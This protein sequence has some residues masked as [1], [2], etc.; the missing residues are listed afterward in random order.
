MAQEQWPDETDLVAGLRARNPRSLETVIKLYSRELFYFTR[1]ILNGVGSVQDAEECL[2]D[3]FIVVWQEFDSFDP[4]RSSL[5][6]WLTMRA[7][8]IALDKRRYLQR[9]R[10]PHI[11]S[12]TIVVSLHEEYTLAQD[13][14]HLNTLRQQQG[15]IGEPMTAGVDALLE[16]RERHA[17]LRQALERLSEL[18]RLIVYLRYFH[19]ASI[20]EIAARTGIS[21]HAVDTHLWRARKSLRGTLQEQLVHDTPAKSTKPV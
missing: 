12:E 1:L 9:R 10:G 13:G 8:Y 18:D 11:P 5:R 2:N 4:A 7:K 19:H 21:K 15:P 14:A 3:L 16:E 17:E 6:T 20:E